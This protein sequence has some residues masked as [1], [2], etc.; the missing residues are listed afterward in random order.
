[1]TKKSLP[2]R[3]PARKKSVLA[4]QPCSPTPSRP[5][6]SAVLANQEAEWLSSLHCNW[7]VP[8]RLQEAER[9]QASGAHSRIEEERDRMDERT[10]LL[11]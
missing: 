10:A 3:K 1:M 6:L 7:S 11:L 4:V 9:G 2:L 8:A 5:S